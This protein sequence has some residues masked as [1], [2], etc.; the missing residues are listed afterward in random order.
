MKSSGEEKTSEVPRDFHISAQEKYLDIPRQK[1]STA[2]GQAAFWLFPL[3][4]CSVQILAQ[5]TWAVLLMIAVTVVPPGP[6]H[7]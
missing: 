7:Q 4:L 2:A 6:Y 3:D 5:F 1:Y